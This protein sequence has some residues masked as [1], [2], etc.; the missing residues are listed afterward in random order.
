MKFASLDL[1]VAVSEGKFPFA[2][3]H[4]CKGYILL[5]ICHTQFWT[6]LFH[7][8]FPWIWHFGHHFLKSFTKNVDFI[9]NSINLT[10]LQPSV[11]VVNGKMSCTTMTHDCKAVIINKMRSLLKIWITQ[12]HWQKRANF[13]SHSSK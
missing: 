12:W 5:F 13:I 3:S 7:G 10:F 1:S 4:G 6:S 2:M 8:I 9:T 11:I